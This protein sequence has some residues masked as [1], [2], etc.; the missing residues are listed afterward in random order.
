MKITEIWKKINRTLLEM[1]LGLIFWGLI[2][3]IVGAI[4]VKQPG[5]YTKSVWFGILMAIAG[6]WHMYRSLDRALGCSEQDAGKI[7]FRGYLFR[8]TF[9]AVVLVIVM[10]TN[11]LNPLVVFLA[12]IGMKVTA[13]LQPLTHKLCN[14]ILN[15]KEQEVK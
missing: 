5:V 4:F 12:Y 6:V 13:Y 14:K 3:Q 1:F 7:I 15:L 11:I 10:V 9:F 2:L 8:Y